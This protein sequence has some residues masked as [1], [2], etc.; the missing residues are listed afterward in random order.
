MIFVSHRHAEARLAEALVELLI[1]ALV[2]PDG[3]LRC[4]SVPGFQ[5]PYG[6][7]I[8]EQLKDD[9]SRAD[10]VFAILTPGS[11][12]SA[13]VLFELGAS[14]AL[15]K[16]LIPIL[17]PSVTESDLPPLLAQYP[18]IRTGAADA[19]PRLRDAIS[20]VALALTMAE[21]PGGRAQAKMD[22]FITACRGWA[23]PADPTVDV[24]RAFE[25]G[26]LISYVYL[27]VDPRAAVK[28]T[29]IEIHASQLGLQLPASWQE[30]LQ[31][32]EWKPM[33]AVV[34]SLAGQIS[35]RTP[36]LAPCYQAA[37]NIAAAVAN[38]DE[39]AMTRA[40]AELS[41]PGDVSGPA[42]DL[43][44]RADR[45]HHYFLTILHGA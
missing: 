41:L 5:L 7:T 25:L 1:S 16:V 26:W 45:V 21:R 20:Q 28:L 10:A 23:A 15:G 39:P 27:V 36:R 12:E 33:E 38:D 2:I 31:G 13:W 30:A 4:T 18:V 22:D 17:A 43:R 40:I 14:W 35:A 44:Q 6:R 42:G 8:S 24:A 9:L 11:L 29:A 34:D 37:L 19:A 3:M 32:H